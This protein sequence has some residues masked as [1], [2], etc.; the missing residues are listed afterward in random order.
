MERP[1]QKL[2]ANRF[3]VQ[4][5]HERRTATL[6]V[7]KIQRSCKARIVRHGHVSSRDRG[8]VFGHVDNKQDEQWE[9]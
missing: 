8:F 6:K 9:R 5:P 7:P 4:Y 3:D 1:K 2:V